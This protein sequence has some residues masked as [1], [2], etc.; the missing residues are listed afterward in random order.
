MH[1]TM[2]VKFSNVMWIRYCLLAASVRV[3]DINYKELYDCK[4]DPLTLTNH[5]L[6]TVT[7]KF[8]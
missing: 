4:W 7:F 1:G 8:L 6:Y 5:T 2:N 3:C